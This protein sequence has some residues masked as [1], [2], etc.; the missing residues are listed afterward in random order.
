MHEKQYGKL[1]FISVI[2]HNNYFIITLDG[3]LDKLL[4]NACETSDIKFDLKYIYIRNV[5][6]CK[7]QQF[8]DQCTKT[9]H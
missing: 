3:D 4:L 6:K 7:N 9:M 5:Q 2:A 1:V 8:T